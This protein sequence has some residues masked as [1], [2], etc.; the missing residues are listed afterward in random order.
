MPSAAYK[1]HA[2]PYR[3]NQ[4]PRLSDAHRNGQ[5]V[6]IVC[7]RCRI[8]RNF[9]PLDIIKLLGDRHVLKLQGS[10]RCEG[11][12]RKDAM[13]AAFVSVIGSE[14]HDFPVRELVEIRV[15]KRPVWRDIKL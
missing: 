15:V 8:R 10:F 14:I 4:I 6:K 13:E 2:H 5:F 1:G 3:E 12:R 11:C 7:T 9:R